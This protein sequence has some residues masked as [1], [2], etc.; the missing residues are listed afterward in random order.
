MAFNFS[1]SN[2]PTQLWIN[3][4]YVDAKS[5]KTLTLNNPADGSLVADNVALAGEQD[6]DLAVEGAEKAFPAWKKMSAVERRTIMNKFADLVEQN[7]T[8]LAELT[9]ITLGAPYGSFGKFETGLCAEVRTA[10]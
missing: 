3:N 4:E 2:L 5:G 7:G 1:K 6:V 9:R 8:A 10:V